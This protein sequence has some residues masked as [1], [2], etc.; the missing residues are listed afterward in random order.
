MHTRKRR[1]NLI[2]IAFAIFWFLYTLIIAFGFI[3]VSKLVPVEGELIS[4]TATYRSTP[5]WQTYRSPHWELA[6]EYAYQYR[7]VSY[8]GTRWRINGNGTTFESVADSRANQMMAADRHIIVWVNPDHPEFAVL[9]RGIGLFAWLFW[10]VLILVTW[11]IQRFSGRIKSA[12]PDVWISRSS[13]QTGRSS[14][15]LE[16]AET[17]VAHGRTAQAIAILES[18]LSEHPQRQDIAQRLSQIRNQRS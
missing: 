1:L 3:Q 9:E 13:S 4:A 16:E 17:Y 8:Q 2:T 14:D 18:A 10:F 15:V 5:G 7:G 6:V 11:L 12:N